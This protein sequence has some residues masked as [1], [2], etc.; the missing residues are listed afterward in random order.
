MA[1][2]V[3]HRLK[4]RGGNMGPGVLICVCALCA[5]CDVCVC[6]MCV[7]VCEMIFVCVF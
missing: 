6:V 4:V 1:P 2:T 5:L 7:P 3:V